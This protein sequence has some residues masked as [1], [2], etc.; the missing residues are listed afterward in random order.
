MAAG[1]ASNAIL[2]RYM[3][4]FQQDPNFADD[5]LRVQGFELQR[6]EMMA[7]LATEF[8]ATI[9]QSDPSYATRMGGVQQMRQGFAGMIQGGAI[10]LQARAVFSESVREDFAAHLVHAFQTMGPD[11]SD[12]DRASIT[13]LLGQIAASDQN[14]NVRSRLS[15]VASGD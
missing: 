9:P 3:A 13:S 15:S 7:G 12:A 4:A 10:S 6:A 11:L 1:D 8:M 2:H 14:T 5:L